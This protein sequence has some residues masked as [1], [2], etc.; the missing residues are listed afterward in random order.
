MRTPTATTNLLAAAARM[1]ADQ[2]GLAARQQL[3]AHGVPPTTVDSAVRAGR[4]LPQAPAVY[5]MPGAPVT[6]FV[7]ALASVLAAGPTALASH[8]TA[9]WLWSLVDRL[10]P[11]H[12]VSVTRWHRRRVPG[13]VVH[14]SRDLDR[15][16]PRRI[17]GVPVAGVG[18]TILDC[19]AMGMDPQPLIDEA[20]RRHA[21]SRTLM[22]AVV[23]AHARSGRTGIGPLRSA[24]ADDEMPHSDFERMVCDW[25]VTEGVTGWE[26]H[27]RLVLPT[28]GPVELDVA[29]PVERVFLELEGADHRDRSL[30]HDHD[31][32]RQN[33]L[34]LAGWQPLRTTYRRWLLASPT[35]LRQI[36]TALDRR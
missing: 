2:L 5:R 36:R 32:E 4:L 21:I 20:R 25:L 7:V 16:L 23:A 34:V 8:L 9:A 17:A 10:P 19:A 6:P 27:H 18:R 14:E 35:L 12:H 11:V 13:C 15:A 29:W 22:P 24:I 30:V 3:L 31:T 26:L 28:F 33:H 1:A